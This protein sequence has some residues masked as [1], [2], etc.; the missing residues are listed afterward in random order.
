MSS[1][2]SPVRIWRENGYHFFGSFCPK[3]QKTYFPKR[4]YCLQC[5]E[6]GLE[7][8][9]IHNPG[10]LI[11]FSVIRNAPAGFEGQA[12]YIVGIVELAPK[13]RVTAQIINI[14]PKKLK[15]GQKL[16]SVF[17][18]IS[19][20]DPESVIHYGLKFQPIMI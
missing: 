5:G 17:R 12:P 1:R 18:R 15:I 16:I 7:K 20:A 8:L 10:R 3:C 2:K 6:N 11:S 4:E 9:E 13:I 14:D 19:V